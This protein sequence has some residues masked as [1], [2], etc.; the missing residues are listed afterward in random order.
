MRTFIIAFLAMSL[1]GIITFLVTKD[2]NSPSLQNKMI[3]EYPIFILK[4]NACVD[5]FISDFYKPHPEAKKVICVST[6]EAMWR[7]NCSCDVYGDEII[8]GIQKETKNTKEQI[9]KNSPV[10]QSASF[11]PLDDFYITEYITHLP[12]NT[13]LPQSSKKLK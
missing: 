3:R 9:F 7:D 11:R 4:E 5:I 2:S 8:D 1:I 6:Y 12:L 10:L 13:I